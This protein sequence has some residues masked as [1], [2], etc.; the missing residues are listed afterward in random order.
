VTLISYDFH[1]SKKPPSQTRLSLDLVL[2]AKPNQ[3][4]HTDII[5]SNET[6]S[7]PGMQRYCW[8]SIGDNDKAAAAFYSTTVV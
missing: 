3:S 5:M 4:R 8:D 2:N 6:L 1:F 7:K